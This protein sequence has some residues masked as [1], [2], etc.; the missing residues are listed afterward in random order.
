MAKA[1][2]ISKEKLAY[3]KNPQVSDF[4]LDKVCFDMMILAAKESG[5]LFLEGYVKLMCDV[6]NLRTAVRIMR[7][8]G[9][10]ELFESAFIPGGNADIKAFTGG[11]PENV[12]LSGPL[13]EAASLGARASRSS[14]SL[15]EFERE[16]DNVLIRYME[17]ARYVAFDERPLI[18]YLAAKE[19]EAQTVRIIMAGKFEN[20]SPQQIRSRLRGVKNG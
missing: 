6:A 1:I 16:L 2:E 20:L 3:T 17:E 8:G 4:I 18:A 19:T 14:E 5:S 12:F 9:S 11:D 15:M 13:R 10:P 7:R